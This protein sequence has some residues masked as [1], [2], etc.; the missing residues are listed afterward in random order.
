M[1][2]TDIRVQLPTGDAE[3]G[4]TLAE[5]ALGCTVCHALT[6]VGPAWAATGDQP[7]LAERAGARIGQADYAGE[8]TTGEQ[9]L[10]ESV[11]QPNAYLVPGFQAGVMP[12]D[13]GERIT[14]QQMADLMAYMLS[15][16]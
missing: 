11:M 6:P 13:F 12:L 2:G 16:R 15:F 4:R 1:M 9:Y 8:A 14:L 7:T 10:L 5:G 3:R